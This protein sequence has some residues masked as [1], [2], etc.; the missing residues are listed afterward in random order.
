MSGF[1][2]FDDFARWQR[3]SPLRVLIGEM[4]VGVW[5]LW[6]GSLGV[7]FLGIGIWWLRSEPWEDVFAIAAGLQ[8]GLGCPAERISINGAGWTKFAHYV[9]GAVLAFPGELMAVGGLV[10]IVAA[11]RRLI[12]DV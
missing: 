7:W 9:P 6:C 5:A 1:Q 3:R 12:R 11:V 10:L 4:V 2:R 8:L